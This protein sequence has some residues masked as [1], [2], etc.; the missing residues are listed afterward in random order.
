VF[1]QKFDETPVDSSKDK[2]KEKAMQEAKEMEFG[3]LFKQNA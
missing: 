2:I 1:D 3:F